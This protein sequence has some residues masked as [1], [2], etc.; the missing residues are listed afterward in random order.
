M[1]SLIV[2]F[3]KLQHNQV[4]VKCNFGYIRVPSILLRIFRPPYHTVAL[5]SAE[6]KLVVVVGLVAPVQLASFF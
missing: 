4:L 2:I 1:L 3:F 6:L 5:M